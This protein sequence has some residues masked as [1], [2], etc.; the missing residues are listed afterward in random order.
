M[1]NIPIYNPKTDKTSFSQYSFY[2]NPLTA[3]VVTSVIEYERPYSVIHFGVDCEGLLSVLKELTRVPFDAYG[4]SYEL[5]NKN[6]HPLGLKFLHV[7]KDSPVLE[8]LIKSNRRVLCIFGKDMHHLFP[9][10]LPFFSHN[11]SFLVRA[12]YSD[13]KYDRDDF[14]KFTPPITFPYELMSDEL[15]GWDCPWWFWLA[16]KSGF[17]GLKRQ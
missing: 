2:G 8:N 1:L 11:S 13:F 5:I 14:D 10:Y 7:D 6:D 17:Y 3:P 12:C 15:I 16:C 9:E 4:V